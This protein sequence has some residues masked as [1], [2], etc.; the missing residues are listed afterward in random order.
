MVQNLER[1]LQRGERIELLVQKTEELQTNA[2]TFRKTSTDLKR[3][4]WWRNVKIWIAVGV[5]ILVRHKLRFLV[6]SGRS[7]LNRLFSPSSP[8]FKLT[9][10]CFPIF[11]THLDSY[12]A[13]F[14]CYLWFQL[15]KVQEEKVKKKYP[16]LKTFLILRRSLRSCDTIKPSLT[17][18]PANSNF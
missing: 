12:L 7:R 4:F 2:A 16:R 5:G 11:C 9:C 1:V 10:P 17:L 3:H 18:Y 15:Q 8:R 6:A 14:L 13:H